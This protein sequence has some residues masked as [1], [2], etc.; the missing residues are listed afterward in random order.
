MSE[1]FSKDGV[2]A[3]HALARAEGPHPHIL[4][5]IFDK[6]QIS[7]MSSKQFEQVVGSVHILNKLLST[8]QIGNCLCAYAFPTS[9]F[10]IIDDEL[11]AICNVK[12]FWRDFGAQNSFKSSF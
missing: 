5:K 11:I 6:R 3:R 8:F 2:Q 7:N 1:T 4:K 9:P 10:L 12:P